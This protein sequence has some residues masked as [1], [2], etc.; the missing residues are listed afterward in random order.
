[1]E[2][3]QSV[4]FDVLGIFQRLDLLDLTVVSINL[5]LII[6]SRQIIRFVYHDESTDRKRL[7]RVHVL[8]ILNLFIIIAFT[9]YHIFL[10]AEEKGAGLKLVSILIVIYVGY[11]SAHI[12]GFIIRQKYGR[13]REIN[14]DKK[15]IETYNSRLLGLFSGIFIFIIVLISVIQILELD[16][17]LEAGGVIGFIGVFF[18]L[19]QNAWAPDIFSGLIIL[20]SGM[21]EEGDVIELTEGADCIGVVFKTKMF[22]T[23]VLNMVNNHRIMIKNS[24]LREYMIH[25]LSKFSSAKGLRENLHFKVSYESSSA[26]V[27]VLFN[28]AFEAAE[29]QDVGVNAEFQFPLDIGVFEVGDH[30]IEWV[31]YYY[32]K[33]IKN[34]I[35][36]RQNFR[37]LILNLS[38]EQSISLATPTTYQRVDK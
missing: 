38:K 28:R 26:D 1:M 11:L 34:L 31:I 12:S 4:L 30:A 7:N 33:D 36:T 13:V 35:A 27:R 29:Q 20:N 5:I 17:L 37:E 23:E 15:S 25:N 6:F 10:S 8:R 14:G 19:T 9:Y 2:F 21:V 16:S 3:I 24:K 32:T 22:H 18:A